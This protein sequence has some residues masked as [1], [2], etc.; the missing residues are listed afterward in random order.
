MPHQR[1]RF[2][3]LF[4]DFF[5][6]LLADFWTDFFAPFFPILLAGRVAFLADF[7]PVF[8]AAFFAALFGVAFFAERAFDFDLAV[9]REGAFSAPVAVAVPADKSCSAKP[10]PC[11]S[12]RIAIV[13]PG[14]SIRGR[15]TNA[16]AFV[17]MS[18]A[19]PTSFTWM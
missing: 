9:A 4:A 3:D 13:P 15:C 17:A 14:M 8:F 18:T 2:A 12:P 16:P 1:R 19:F 10:A 6:G 7:F 5:A 11:G